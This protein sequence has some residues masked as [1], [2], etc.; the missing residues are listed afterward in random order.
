DQW[1]DPLHGYAYD[2][3]N[4]D[5]L[6]RL[7]TVKDGRIVLPGG[8]SY[9]V[10]VIPGARRMSPDSN[11]MSPQAIQKL[12]QL[13][14]DGTTIIVNSKPDEAPG[15][16]GDNEVKQISTELLNSA[17][18]RV[19]IGAY[20]K[21]DLKSLGIAKDIIVTDQSGNYV[22]DIAWNHRRGKGFDIYFIANQEPKERGFTL[23]LRTSGRIPEL[24]N[25]L[26]GEMRTAGNW[27]I[28][29]GRT[30]LPLKLDANGSVFVVLQKPV[31][32]KK[33]TKHQ[34]W[35]VITPVQTLKED[36]TVKFDTAFGGPE[37]AVHF[38][39]LEDWSQNAENGIKYYS[40]TANYSQSFNWSSKSRNGQVW[41]DLCKVYDL[42]DVYVN[43]VHCG[44]AWT[45]PY[46]VNIG[47]ALKQGK[48]EIRI[49]VSNTWAN[50]IIG[51]HAIPGVK[52]ITWTN[53]AYRLEGKPLLPAGLLGPVKIVKLNY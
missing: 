32:S 48:N 3:I 37:K 44:T 24:W 31:V 23:S 28:E 17:H 52:P 36:W 29:K 8:A 13:V 27:K 50:R 51:D 47:K 46:R 30:V 15:L 34:N 21:S 9:G 2:S 16:K 25:A 45:Y 12:Q 41:L 7:A 35:A 1:V 10:L 40:G 4:L 6:L 43:G 42:A 33:V 53:A 26:T 19:L 14:K 20:E 18:S 11:L 5:A 49:E 39:G 38:T 22:K